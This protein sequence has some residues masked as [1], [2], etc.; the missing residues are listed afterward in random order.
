[1]ELFPQ[2]GVNEVPAV[3]FGTVQ[4]ESEIFVFPLIAAFA[5]EESDST[6]FHG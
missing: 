6:V 1:M 5:A 2:I 3:A 4:H